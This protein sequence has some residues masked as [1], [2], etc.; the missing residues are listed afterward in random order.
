[1]AGLRV[2]KLSIDTQSFDY[3]SLK[4][5][6]KDLD[7][8]SIAHVNWPESYPYKPTVAFQIGYTAGFVAL[9]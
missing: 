7:W 5:Q 1:M 9:H 3:F 4:Q 8:Q 6:M 2:K